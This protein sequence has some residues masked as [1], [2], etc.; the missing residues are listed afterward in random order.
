MSIAA[1]LLVRRRISFVVDRSGPAIGTLLSALRQHAATASAYDRR[2][3]EGTTSVTVRRATLC[4][5]GVDRVVEI[6]AEHP[7][8]RRVRI[9]PVT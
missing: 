6:L 2:V 8:V 5:D 4:A 9:A 1:T 7:G 3:E